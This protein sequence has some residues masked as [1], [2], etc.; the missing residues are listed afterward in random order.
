MRWSEKCGQGEGCFRI[1]VAE[2]SSGVMVPE[3]VA[4]GFSALKV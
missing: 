1:Q 3:A 2:C 4:V